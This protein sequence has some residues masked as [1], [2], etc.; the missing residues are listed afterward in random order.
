MDKDV[1]FFEQMEKQEK[2]VAKD[3]IRLADG[4]R[5][6]AIKSLLEVMALDSERHARLYEAV[7][8]ILEPSRRMIS[9]ADMKR[10][11]EEV[12][13]HVREESQHL[14]DVKKMAD[15]AKDSKVKIIL[16]VIVDDEIN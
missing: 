1:T 15:S 12:E 7:A 13:R 8:D 6:S 11:Q 9:S 16:N 10:I 14:E 5:S 2:K 4:I 3:I